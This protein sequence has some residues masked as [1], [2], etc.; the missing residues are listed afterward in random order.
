MKVKK[1]ISKIL[2]NKWVLNVISFLALFNV[3]GYMIMGKF[4]SVVFFFYIGSPC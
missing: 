2:T 3:I 4:N 1:T